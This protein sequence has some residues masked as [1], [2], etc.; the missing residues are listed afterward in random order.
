MDEHSQ[1]GR[2]AVF[3]LIPQLLASDAPYIDS[4]EGTSNCIETGS[5]YDDI[6]VVVT[7]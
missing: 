7:F 1:E 5:I 2:R 3:P 4:V 6:E